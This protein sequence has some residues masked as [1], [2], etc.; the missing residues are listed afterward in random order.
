MFDFIAKQSQ[1]DDVFADLT[2]GQSLSFTQ[3]WQAVADKCHYLQ[4]ENRQQ[5]QQYA[6]WCE[7]SVEFLQWL[8][9]MVLVGK[10]VILPPHGQPQFKQQL[11]QQGIIWFEPP[12]DE[13]LQ[14]IDSTRTDI[15]QWLARGAVSSQQQSIIFYTSGSTGQAKQ[16]PRS[17]QQLLLEARCILQDLAAPQPFH[18]CASVSHQ[19]LYGLTFHLFVPLLAGQSFCATQWLYPEQIEQYVSDYRQQ[20]QH[21]VILISSPA[22]LKR[23]AG[24]FAFQ[25]I[26]MIVSSGGHLQHGVRSYYRQGILEIFGS[27]ET[28]AIAYKR[29]D[30]ELWQTLSD[31][32]ISVNAAQQLCIKTPRAYQQDWIESSDCVRL[33]EQ[34]FELL[35]RSDRIVKLEEKRISLDEIEAKINQLDDVQECATVLIEHEQRAFLSVVIALN[36]LAWQRLRQQGKRAMVDSF[37]QQLAP[38][39]ERIA[40]PKHWR[41]VAQLP[42][43]TQSK[44]NRQWVKNLFENQ[45][46]P[47][48]LSQQHADEMWSCQLQF[49]PELQCFKGHF[50]GFPIYPGV[51]QLGFLIYFAQQQWLDLSHCQGYEQV[52]FQEL[53]RPYDVLQ[54]ELKR[55]Q[56]KV[57]FKLCKAEQIVAS[58]RL[59]FALKSDV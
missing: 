3:F 23:C 30:N 32:E 59:V 13:E 38:Q 40:M 12:S 6:L 7:Q 1:C 56:Q 16:I 57:L 36:E 4:Q 42:R 34:G 41:F 9:A 43:N 51:G 10:T 53:I 37:K 5:I 2:Q 52:K 24:V 54:L 46:Y 58:G 8:W 14:A 45:Q 33:S 35:G 19:H 27:S 50:D 15:Q 44:L 25:D 21:D 28:G 29:Q 31:V 20:N 11:Q 39:L 48:I 55:E 22:L 18:V 47:H 49:S 17:L 26:Q